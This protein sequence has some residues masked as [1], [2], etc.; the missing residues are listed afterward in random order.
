MN[1]W[2]S[3]LLLV[4]SALVLQ[5]T[6]F[7]W[8]LPVPL[9]P[10]LLLCLLILSLPFLSYRD[11][12]FFTILLGTAKEA[13][14]ASVPGI[15]VLVYLLFFVSGRLLFRR[16]NAESLPLLVFFSFAGVLLEGGISSLL[17]LFS[18]QK[19]IP[20]EYLAAV[21]PVQASVTALLFAAILWGIA[22]ID[23]YS[24]GFLQI[25]GLENIGLD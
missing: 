19:R 10:Q 14:S 5:G 6:V 22:R 15:A 9:R 16:F 12:L 8:F 13:L 24:P 21:L 1:R 18:D 4:V 11:G 17:L 2:W 3:L 25:R 7:A 23:R 20:L